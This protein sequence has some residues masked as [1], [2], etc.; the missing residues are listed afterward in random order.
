[1][2]S[3]RK[4]RRDTNTAQ[5]SEH[6]FAPLASRKQPLIRLVPK[7]FTHLGIHT[8]LRRRHAAKQSTLHQ[9][10]ACSKKLPGYK[11]NTLH[12]AAASP[13]VTGNLVGPFS[14]KPLRVRSFTLSSATAHHFAFWEIRT[15]QKSATNRTT[16]DRPHKRLYTPYRRTARI[17]IPEVRKDA[18]PPFSYRDEFLPEYLSLLTLLVFTIRDSPNLAFWHGVLRALRNANAIV[19]KSCIR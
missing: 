3:I 10:L 5:R 12:K 8:P 1:M 15:R 6:Q 18:L 11:P 2:I 17:W 19:R 13:A 14:Q 4:S 16:K 7:R 9:T